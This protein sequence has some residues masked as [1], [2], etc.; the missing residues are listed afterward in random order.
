[1]KPTLISGLGLLGITSLG[2]GFADNI[3]LLDTA[4]FVQ[5][6]G[7]ALMWAAGMTWLVSAAPPERRGELIGSALA[8]AIIGVLL[9]PVL[10]GAATL[11]G[12]EPVFAACRWPPRGSPLWAWRTPGVPPAPSPGLPALAGALRRRRRADRLLALHAARRCSPA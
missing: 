1:M 11:V 6:V 12:T 2:F 9:G 10:G 5:G 4:R 8:A 3:V 7:G